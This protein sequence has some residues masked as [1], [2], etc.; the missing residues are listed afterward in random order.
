MVRAYAMAGDRSRRGG[1]VA[2]PARSPDLTPLDF[3]LWGD[4]KRKVYA[5]QFDNTRQL[6]SLIRKAFREVRNDSLV[7]TRV[8]GNLKR[9]AETCVAVNG[10]HFENI[11]RVM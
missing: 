2:W 11:L 8:R 4:I 9:R 7:L 1:P 10:A 5:T 3:Y 6:K